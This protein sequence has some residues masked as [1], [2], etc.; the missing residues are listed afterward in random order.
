M[1]KI[2]RVF[3]SAFLAGAL[4]GVVLFALQAVFV[5]PLILQAENYENSAPAAAAAQENS[6]THDHSTHSHDEAE[7]EG[8]NRSLL[9]ALADVLTGIGFALLLAAGY[10]LRNGSIEW[11]RGLAWGLAGF[12][13]FSLAPALGLPP[14]LPG[15]FAAPLADRQLWWFF[16]ALATAAGLGFCAFSTSKIWRACGLLLIVLPHV[17][18]APQPESHGGLAPDDLRW[19]FQIAALV[20]MAVFWLI[21]G[22]LSGYFYRR[23]EAV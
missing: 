23:F 19:Q 13:A 6:A 4:A 9:T 16:A 20:T 10:A 7:D 15:D 22:G 14:E 8:D 18:G 21:L 5:T 17:V 1:S 2:R 12:A 11:R 3:Y